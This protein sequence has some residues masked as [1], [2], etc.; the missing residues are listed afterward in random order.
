M[1]SKRR[2][3]TSSQKPPETT[4]SFFADRCLGAKVFPEHLKKAGLKI[5]V[6]DDV[7]DQKE[8]DPWIFYECGRKGLILITSDREFM[9]LFT[10]M[11]AISLGRTKVIA[12]TGS[13]YNSTV[14]AQ[15]FLGAMKLIVKE[16]RKSGSESFIA[17]ACQHL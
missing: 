6:H 14:R 16:I 1:P 12:F 4:I 13:T 8:R 11:A 10:H 15:S 3:S 9:K 7:Y 2:S 17:G 5:I